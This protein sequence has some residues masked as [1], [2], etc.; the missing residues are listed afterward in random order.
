MLAYLR[1]WVICVHFANGWVCPIR[2]KFIA[3]YDAVDY[4]WSENEY[5]T[6]HLGANQSDHHNVIYLNVAF[7]VPRIILQGLVEPL[8]PEVGKNNATRL[9]N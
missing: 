4:H 3:V 7:C 6:Q 8:D 5:I 1:N 2:T 9:T